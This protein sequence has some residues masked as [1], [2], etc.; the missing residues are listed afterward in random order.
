[1]YTPLALSRTEIWDISSEVLHTPEY[2]K[3]YIA[4]LSHIIGS[5]D[6][7]ILDTACGTGFPSIDLFRIGYLDITC[8]DADVEALKLIQS[9]FSIQ[10]FNPKVVASR[11]QDLDSNITDTFDIVL[12]CDNSFVYL[13]TWSEDFALA[14]NEE[15]IFNGMKTVLKNFY[16]RLNEKGKV[17]VGLAKNNQKDLKEKVVDIG[18]AEYKGK[19]VKIVWKLWYD[20][21]VRIKKWAIVTYIDGEEISINYK[22]YLIDQQELIG[23]MNKVGFKDIKVISIDGIYD[24]LLIG[25]K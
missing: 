5:T 15:E 18:E 7:T 4:A 3:K 11:W 23:L 12:N 14:K 22:S 1:M 16:N 10:G 25:F 9:R 6:K 17:V 2:R 24:D 13:D 21:S 8:V 19:K 20:W